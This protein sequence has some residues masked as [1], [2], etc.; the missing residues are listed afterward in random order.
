MI[1]FNAIYLMG[2][3][4]IRH[5]KEANVWLIVGTMTLSAFVVGC[6]LSCEDIILLGII[7]MFFETKEKP[8][9]KKREWRSHKSRHICYECMSS[10]K[11]VYFELVSGFRY[12]AKCARKLNKVINSLDEEVSIWNQVYSVSMGNGMSENG[13]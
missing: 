3:L 8:E 13:S 2:I 12:C 4:L 7:M 5:G 11:R 9:N 1:V 10:T 6:F